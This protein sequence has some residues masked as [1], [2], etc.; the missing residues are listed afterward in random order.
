MLCR[1]GYHARPRSCILRC[2]VCH[3]QMMEVGN[4]ESFT[5]D[6]AHFGLWV[7][8]S[9]PLILGFDMLD[10]AKMERS[11]PIISNREAIVRCNLWSS[12]PAFLTFQ[13]LLPAA[14]LT[15][16]ACLLDMHRPSIKHG[17]V[18]PASCT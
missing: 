10:D 5:A 8:T 15:I 1:R 12:S 13:P 16:M 4:L 11:W 3:S 17:L 2:W 9:S 6:E 14:T 18:R 7:I